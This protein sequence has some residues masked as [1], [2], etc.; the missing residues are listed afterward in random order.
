MASTLFALDEFV[1]IVHRLHLLIQLDLDADLVLEI[2]QQLNRVK[3]VDA[4][5]GEGALGFYGGDIAAGAL[6]NNSRNRVKVHNNMPP[7]KIFIKQFLSFC[8]FY[9]TFLLFPDW[10]PGVPAAFPNYKVFFNK[11]AA[12]ESG[13]PKKP[14]DSSE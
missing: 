3:G 13:T 4:K 2:H 8:C 14:P 1:Q 6:G 12:G 5:L 7:K 10:F 11:S 9:Y